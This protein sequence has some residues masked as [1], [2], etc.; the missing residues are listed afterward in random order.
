MDAAFLLSEKG[1]E[2]ADDETEN[3]QPDAKRELSSSSSS[4][5]GL[6]RFALPLFLLA[7]L[8]LLVFLER[9]SRLL[10][11]ARS[12]RALLLLPKTN[13]K[14]A[15]FLSGRKNGLNYCDSRLF[16]AFSFM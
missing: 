1:E 6:G 16:C 7:F 15:R 4:S 9:T 2:I 12:L 8:L 14:Y 3:Q 11:I 10:G 13:C 5:L